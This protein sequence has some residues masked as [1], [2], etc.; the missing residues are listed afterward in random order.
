VFVLDSPND[1]VADDGGIDT[2]AVRYNTAVLSDGP[3]RIE[4][5]FFIGTGN[6]SGRGNS[7]NNTIISDAGKDK[8]SGMGGRDILDAGL[9]N[10]TLTGGTSKDVFVFNSKLGTAATDRKVNFDTITDFKVTD[11]T[12]WLDRAVFKKLGKDGILNKSYF[13]I[14]T[15]AKDKNDYIVYDKAKGALY[16]D[17]DG[18]GRSGA[19][20]F[21]Q[22]KKGLVIDHKDFFII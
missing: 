9:G 8:L 5:L 15:Q 6:F 13:T 10:D 2:L 4:K 12:I 21:A 22:L 7:L 18:S 17:A 16:Y 19:V 14:G 20:K 1:Q 3:S 11:D